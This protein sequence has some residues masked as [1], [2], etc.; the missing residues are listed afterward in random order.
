MPD[1]LIRGPL[2]L[3]SADAPPLERMDLSIRAGRIVEMGRG[4]RGRESDRVIDAADGIV[5][6]GL[7]NA[8]AHTYETF[9]RGGVPAAPMEIWALYGHPVLGNRPRTPD[10]VYWRTLLPCLEMLRNGVTSVV[11]DVSL[12][13]DSR[14]ELVEAIMQAYRDAGIRAWVSVKLMDRPLLATVPVDRGRVP[15]SILRDLGRVRLPDGRALMG[16]MRRI[17]RRE[18]RLG[19]I[20]R[21]IPNPAAPQRCTEALLRGIHRL[22]VER[23]FPF[24]IHVQETRLQAVQGPRTYGTSMIGHLERL[25]VLTER[26]SIMH[27]VWL[28]DDDVTRIAAAGATVVH[29]PASNLKLGSGLASLRQLL[30]AGVNV[31][32]GCDGTSS[33]DGQSILE[34]MKLAALV[35]HVTDPDYRRWLTPS[36][37]FRMATSGGARAAR[38]DT[39]IGTIESGRRAGMVLLDR[40]TPAFSP[41]NDPIAQLV[42][43]ESGHAVRMVIVDGR[44]VVEEGRPVTADLGKA[45][46]RLQEIGERLRVE[47]TRTFAIARR[48][49]PRWREMIAGAHDTPLP[50]ER[51]AWG[52]SRTAT[53]V[54]TAGRRPRRRSSDNDR[55]DPSDDESRDASVRSRS[56]PSRVRRIR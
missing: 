21:V 17:M 9:N 42:Y 34:A 5:I 4:L 29:N 11:D 43:A 22:A 13:F 25:C 18:D 3:R 52:T 31:A 19:G 45:C 48:L 36:E 38:W 41:L 51:L 2:V 16:W 23:D 39:A 7:V 50:I 46:D 32:L 24:V 56:R 8:H 14:D 37:V 55:N 54:T 28:D 12:Y 10:E 26:T 47:R 44:I 49:E 20:A 1:L 40:R 53:T 27:G 33:N 6:P 30:H 15:R 35:H